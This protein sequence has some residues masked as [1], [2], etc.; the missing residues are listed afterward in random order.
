MLHFS[1]L[2]LILL[3]VAISHTTL[4]VAISHTD[5]VYLICDFKRSLA[6]FIHVKYGSL[7]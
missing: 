7:H 1:T 2:V 5:D 3:G 4:G 6:V